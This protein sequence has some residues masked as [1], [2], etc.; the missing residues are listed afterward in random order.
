MSRLRPEQLSAATAFAEATLA[1]L[2]DADGV[3][4]VSACARMAG[5]FLFR[6]FAHALNRPA[7]GS[8]LSLPVAGAHGPRLIGLLQNALAR[9]G[10]AVDAG[11][12]ELEHDSLATPAL[13]FLA[14][15]SR[16]APAF[17]PIRQQQG[18]SLEEAADAA[19]VAVAM[20]IKQG[21]RTLPAQA[22]FAI[23]VYAFIE[24]S[25]TVPAD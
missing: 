2:P 24:G 17:E 15:Q 18:L 20:L 19:A 1:A 11:R 9:L 10:L 23:A 12:A 3:T 16:L 21:E 5:S 13:G 8:V 25:K 22:A 7:P 4:R 14:S 6:N